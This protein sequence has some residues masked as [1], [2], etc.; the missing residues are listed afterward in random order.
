MRVSLFI[1]VLYVVFG[2][3]SNISS[4]RIVSIL[5][6]SM[7]AGTLIYPFT[8]TLRDLMHKKM[9]KRDAD[10]IVILAAGVNLLMFAVFYI[11]S[12]LPPDMSLGVQKEFGQVLNPAW[13]IVIG[14]ITAMVIAELLD[15]Y[16]YEAVRRRVKGK[17]WLRVLLSNGIS[18]PVDTAIMIVIAFAGTMPRK[19]LIAI[20]VS[21]VIVKLCITLI[22]MVWIYFVKEGVQ[23]DKSET[24]NV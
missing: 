1:A 11:V 17:Q 4:L 14:S 21:N 16:I 3:L 20:I 22:S 19:L 13:R 18:I 15:S 7:D 23:L 8:F 9:G 2:I 5:K 24:Q 6:M 12:I 10:F